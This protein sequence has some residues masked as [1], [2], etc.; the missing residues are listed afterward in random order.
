[1]LKAVHDFIAS[2]LQSHAERATDEGRELRLAAAALRVEVSRIDGTVGPEE[3]GAMRAGIRELLEL[4][5]AETDELIGLAEQRSLQAVSL[6]ELASVVDRWMPPRGKQRLVELLWL[7]A[8]ADG[9]KNALE[10]Q[11]IRTIA[12][13]LHVPHADFVAAR[14]RARD[15]GPPK[16]ARTGGS[17]EA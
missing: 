5:A 1:M 13:L 16:P 10:E 12:G 4:S 17:G 11:V 2:Q 6:Y 15:A 8:F 3:L 14:K 7:V 9:R